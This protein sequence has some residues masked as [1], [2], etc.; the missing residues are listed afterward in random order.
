MQLHAE[1]IHGP[2]PAAIF[3]HYGNTAETTYYITKGTAKHDVS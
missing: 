3:H 2:P 1:A